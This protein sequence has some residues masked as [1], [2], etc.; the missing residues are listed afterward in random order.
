MMDKLLLNLLTVLIFPAGLTVLLTGLAF[1]WLNRKLLARFQ[2]R[3]GPRWFQPLADVVK[4]LAKE[5]VVPEA[6]DARLFVALPLIALAGCLTAALSIPIWGVDPLYNFPG[7]L[8]ITLFL[9]SL[10][11]L[12][13][14]L[15]GVNTLDRFSL[16]GATRAFTQLFSYEA[17]F[18]LA[19]LGPAFVAGTWQINEIMT[20]GAEQWLIITQPI[21][22]V[23]AM[24]GLIGKLELP[25]FD[26]PEAE[27]EIV[28]GSLTEYSGRGLALFRMGK[29][30]ALV[31]GLTL[32]A[33]L[34]LGGIYDPLSF[35]VKTGVLLS[36]VVILEALFTRLRIDQSVGLWWRDGTLIVL[37]QWLGTI[38]WQ[39]VK[40]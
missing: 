29:F 9:L 24:I 11:T 13:L 10:L 40:A 32:I 33:A 2:N 25:P 19:L 4:L 7:D 3:V 30:V 21:G 12:C 20:Y 22:F 38:L 14:G 31:S 15:A 8:I 36:I 16:V 1:D 18:L 26:A 5:E 6:V 39:G 23:V 37:L 17:P 27:T 35:L 34:Y 28:A